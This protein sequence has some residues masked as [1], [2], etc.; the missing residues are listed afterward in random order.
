MSIIYDLIAIWLN[1][2]ATQAANFPS[3][4]GTYQ[5]KMPE[6]VIKLKKKQ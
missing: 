5:E 2:K 3:S 4:H 1:E 6:A